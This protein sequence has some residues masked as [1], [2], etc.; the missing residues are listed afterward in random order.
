LSIGGLHGTVRKRFANPA[1]WILSN[2]RSI[3]EQYIFL[4]VREL[5]SLDARLL[6]SL[7]SAIRE[8]AFLFAVMED[9][10]DR[11]IWETKITI[12]DLT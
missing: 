11:S 3:R 8:D 10:L 7:D 4:A 12:K 1:I 5:D 2:P 6:N 9:A